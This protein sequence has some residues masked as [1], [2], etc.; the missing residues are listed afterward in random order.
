MVFRGLPSSYV[1]S[2][3]NHFAFL[4][5]PFF[6]YGILF[7]QRG[8]SAL[9]WLEPRRTAIG[10]GVAAMALVTCGEAVVLGGLAKDGGPASWGDAVMLSESLS[11]HVLALVAVGWLITRPSRPT[12]TR[13]WLYGVGLRS[14]GIL[15]L[16][17]VVLIGCVTALWQARR[18]LGIVTP[19]GIPPVYMLSPWWLP[20]AAC[21]GVAL[22]LLAMKWGERAL[23]K[24]TA[25]LLF[26]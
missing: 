10:W 6:V 12:A 3:W 26:G 14:L 5:L 23:G 1:W 20:L 2:Q 19:P 13:E 8:E 4:K 16:Q 11:L 25:S 7:S 24:K 21:A 18:V 22:P 9:A 17:D 15:A